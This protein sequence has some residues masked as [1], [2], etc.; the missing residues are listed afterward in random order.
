[1]GVCQCVEGEKV[2]GSERLSEIEA[3]VWYLAKML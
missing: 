3:L 2:R 1:M